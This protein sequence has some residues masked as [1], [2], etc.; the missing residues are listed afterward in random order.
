MR[1]CNSLA[2]SFLALSLIIPPASASGA[3]GQLPSFNAANSLAGH[4]NYKQAVDEYKKALA[5]QPNNAKVHHMYGRTLA[6]MGLLQ[7]AVDEY[8]IALKLTSKPDAELENDI[9][10][11]MAALGTDDLPEAAIHLKKAVTLSPKFIAAFNNLGVALSRLGDYRAARDVFTQSLKMQPTNKSIEKKLADMN[12]KLGQSKHFDYS[13]PKKDAK[14]PETTATTAPA[15]QT[16]ESVKVADPTKV[17]EPVKV[18]QPATS[19]DGVKVAQPIRTIG[20]QE[21]PPARA[22][23][24]ATPKPPVAAVTS[25]KPIDTAAP[26]AVSPKTTNV[27][28]TTTSAPVAGVTTKV[29]GVSTSLDAEPAS[30]TV[31]TTTVKTTTTT[32]DAT[33]NSSATSTTTTEG[34]TTGAGT[35]SK[36]TTTG[37]ASSTATTTTGVTPTTTPDT[38]S[39]TAETSPT[40]AT[41]PVSETSPTSPIPASGDE[42]KPKDTAP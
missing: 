16:A 8:R 12:T 27:L 31:T 28:P 13:V 38:A 35:G 20:K 17:S 25:S 37:E 29:D 14:A 18:A 19:P 21:E 26:V 11:A 36:A 4:G 24:K 9:G 34:T 41:P 40:P 22:V 7:S 23:M 10:V 5:A 39:P 33:L 3:S 2:L 6:L 1:I 15:G 30:P 32:S 42:V